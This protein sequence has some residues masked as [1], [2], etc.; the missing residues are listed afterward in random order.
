MNSSCRDVEGACSS[1]KD[2]EISD[3]EDV[4]MGTIFLLAMSERMLIELCAGA[5]MVD[6]KTFQASYVQACAVRSVG[7]VYICSVLV[8]GMAYLWARSVVLF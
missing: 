3:H 1:K 2:Y 5:G 8:T 7:K 6:R 4:C